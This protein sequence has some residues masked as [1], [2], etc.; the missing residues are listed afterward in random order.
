MEEAIKKEVWKVINVVF[1]L[2]VSIIFILPYLVQ[3]STYFHER[4]HQKILDKYG[5]ENAHQL[6]LL[7]TI[8]NFFDPKSEKLGVTKFSL[9]QYKVLD[10]YQRTKINIA[11]VISDLKFLFLIG[12]YLSLANVYL[13]YRFKFGKKTGL[14]WILAVNWVLFMWLLAL[15]QITLANITQGFGDVYQ[16][17]RYLRV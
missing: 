3:V 8:P 14:G 4:A 11:G 5:V 6:N 12:I 1:F 16:L 13:F 2:F 17:I 15:I 9:E 10:K 7:E